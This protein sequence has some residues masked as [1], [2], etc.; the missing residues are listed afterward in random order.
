MTRRTGFSTLPARMH[1]VHTCARLV[2]PFTTA[3][4]RWMFGFQRRFERT[5]E[6]LRLMPNDGFLPQSSQTD[7]MDN[8]PSQ[9]PRRGRLGNICPPSNL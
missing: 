8:S 1:D 4:T 3:R 9:T 5:W 6:W 7:A 2:V